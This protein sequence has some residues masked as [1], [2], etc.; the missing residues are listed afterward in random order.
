MEGLIVIQISGPG[1]RMLEIRWEVKGWQRESRVI[2][3]PQRVRRIRSW[4]PQ[5]IASVRENG[6]G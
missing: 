2:K 3:A 6:Q 4:T 5:H 1:A